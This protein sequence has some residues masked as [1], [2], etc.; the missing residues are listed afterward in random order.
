MSNPTPNA[1]LLSPEQL[2]AL[3]DEQQRIFSQ[4]HPADQQFFAR[5][6][7]PASLGPALERKWAIIQANA[8]L[9]DLDRQT[10]QALALPASAST[11]GS[12]TGPGL[13]EIAAGAAGVAG[14]VGIGALA[15]KLAPQGVATWRGVKP[16][17]LVDPLLTAFARQ[18]Q[19]DMRFEPP[20]EN[21]VLSGIV[22]LRTR[23]GLLP[24]LT[25]TLAPLQDAV[26]VGV[27]K[28]E[29]Q[30]IIEKMKEG[31]Q[32][33]LGLV[34]DGFQ[35]AR[36]GGPGGLIDMAGKVLDK[37]GDIAKVVHDLN[38]EDKAWE[39][40]QRVADPLQAR[41]DEAQRA[42]QAARIK[43]EQAWDDHITCPRCRV[44]FGAG[45]VECR[46]CGSARLPAPD[47]PDPRRTAPQDE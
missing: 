31:G 32:K 13:G 44:E 37:G 47:Q 6:F 27:S 30:T 45:D 34:Q 19:T 26:Q 40:V 1:S 46:V 24:A 3:S 5:S 25:I 7:S 4:L 8:P 2:A 9:V 29:S 23:Q 38:L 36:Q 22:E 20:G 15:A 28:I 17:D 35:A 43:L 16:R 41:F 14:M 39:V 42:A 21:G 12:K 33:L 10:R 11:P 18:E